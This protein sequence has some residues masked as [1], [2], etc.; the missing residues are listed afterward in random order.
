MVKKGSKFGKFDGKSD[1]DFTIIQVKVKTAKVLNKKK[2]C[3][4]ESYE[5]VI[6]RVL[7]EL[8]K[9]EEVER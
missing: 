9:Q 1:E 2:V 4:T 7:D 5:S 8:K 6:N 3:K